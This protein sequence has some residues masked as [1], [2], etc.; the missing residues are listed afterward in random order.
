MDLAPPRRFWQIRQKPA[1]SIHAFSKLVDAVIGD[2]RVKGLLITM[3]GFG[4]GMATATS[5]RAELLRLRAAGRE[6]VFHLP[7]GGDTKELYVA[8][9]GTRILV[10]PQATL[11]PLGFS[12]NVRYVKGVL[13]K[14][15]LQPEVLARGEYKSAGEQLVPRHDERAPA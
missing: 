10:G 13:E 9:A 11:A 15:G 2:P 8:V 1:L 14:A 7:L 5:L 3:K 12:T 4:A 6:I